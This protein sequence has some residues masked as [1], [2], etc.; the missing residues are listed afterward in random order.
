MVEPTV[1]EA[2]VALQMVQFSRKMR[3]YD[4]IVEGDALQIVNA[5]RVTNFGHIVTGIQEH[6]HLLK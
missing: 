5:I 3:F 1:A 6:M 2:L 4:F